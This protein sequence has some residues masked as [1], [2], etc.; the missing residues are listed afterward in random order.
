V[1]PTFAGGF[2]SYQ[3]GLVVFSSTLQLKTSTREEARRRAEEE[4]DGVSRRRITAL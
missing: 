1:A 4:E 2:N 3:R